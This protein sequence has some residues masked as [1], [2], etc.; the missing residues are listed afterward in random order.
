MIFF[1]SFRFLCEGKSF[2]G[3]PKK[4]S[5]RRSTPHHGRGGGG[6]QSMVAEIDATQDVGHFVRVKAVLFWR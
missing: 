1:P 3:E 6:L 4:N 2:N 5:S